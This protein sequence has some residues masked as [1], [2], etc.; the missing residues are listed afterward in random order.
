M[1]GTRWCS[2]SDV[3][4]MSRTIT[5]SS[6]LAS[7]VTRRCR[8]GSASIPEKSSAYMSATRRGVSTSPSR[9]D[10][11]ADRVEE[12]GDRGADA[13]DVDGHQPAASGP[14]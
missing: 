14:T 5:I 9:V 3:N 2:H 4:G 12:L 6:W 11:L 8:A 10:V 1:N 13:L 7:N